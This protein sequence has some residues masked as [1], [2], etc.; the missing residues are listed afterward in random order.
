MKKILINNQLDLKI[1]VELFKKEGFHWEDEEDSVSDPFPIVL[2]QHEGLTAY[3]VN[4]DNH[5]DAKTLKEYSK[6]F[7]FVITEVTE[8][9]IPHVKE[10]TS[11]L[12]LRVST[13]ETTL[14]INK[15]GRIEI[16]LDINTFLDKF[17]DNLLFK[18]YLF[19]IDNP[20]DLNFLKKSGETVKDI[21]ISNYI[22]NLNTYNWEPTNR[23]KDYNNRKDLLFV[24]NL[25]LLNI[26]EDFTLIGSED[27]RNDTYFVNVVS[28]GF[29]S[30]DYPKKIIVNSVGYH[31]GIKILKSIF[32]EFDNEVYKSLIDITSDTIEGTSYSGETISVLKNNVTIVENK[33]IPVGEFYVINSSKL[34][35]RYALELKNDTFVYEG[36]EQYYG[37]NIIVPL[38][39]TIKYFENKVYIRFLKGD[40]KYYC[41]NDFAFVDGFDEMLEFSNYNGEVVDFFNEDVFIKINENV[42]DKD[43]DSLYMD[44]DI[45]YLPTFEEGEKLYSNALK[46]DLDRFDEYVRNGYTNNDR[47][48][49]S[50]IDNVK[51][52]LSVK[53]FEL[54][55]I[56]LHRKLTGLEKIDKYLILCESTFEINGRQILISVTVFG[57]KLEYVYDIISYDDNSLNLKLVC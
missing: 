42:Y 52:S 44:N 15:K 33:Q 49:T 32:F 47:N 25:E 51:Y 8:L 18:K 28:K 50:I 41:L 7:R 9:L 26:T 54:R 57:E 5:T 17:D 45:L 4:L 29:V 11:Y 56:N 22:F 3:S 10:I 19:T 53:N 38:S 12:G 1:G 14:T 35:N 21:K 34:C 39:N 48:S 31:K 23:K 46:Y 55:K 43:G 6:D 30:T 16:N 13:K 2:I 20:S 27:L 24:R 36:K 40:D 37:E